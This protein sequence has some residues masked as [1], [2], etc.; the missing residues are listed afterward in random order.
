[1]VPISAAQVRG[2]AALT[3]LRLTDAEV[4]VMRGQL[5]A[6]LGHFESLSRIDTAGVEPAGHTTD[7]DSVFRD[8]VTLPPLPRSDVL[9]NAP[10]TE[11]EFIR[12]R[13]V[14]E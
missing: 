1:L 7:S 14:L 5:S 12:V 3:R 8:D 11:G 4:E 10:D 13:P 6:I 2:I 9:S